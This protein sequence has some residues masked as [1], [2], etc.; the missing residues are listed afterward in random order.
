[1]VITPLW[2]TLTLRPLWA[3]SVPGQSSIYY[4]FLILLNFTVY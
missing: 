4:L 3:A 1:M 2:S